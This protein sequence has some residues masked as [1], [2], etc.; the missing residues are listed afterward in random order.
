MTID[1]CTLGASHVDPRTNVIMTQTSRGPEGDEPFGELPTYS[2]LGVTSVPWD[3]DDNGAAE[4]IVVDGVGTKGA[5]IGAR[6]AR[7]AKIT[8]NAKPGDTIIHTTGPSQAAQ[9]QLKEA[10]RQSVLCTKD[11]QDKQMV[12]MLDGKNDKVAVLAFGYV[13]QIDRDTGISLSSKN[14]QHGIEITDSGVLVRGKVQL[15]GKAAPPGMCMAA[16]TPAT[17]AAIMAL[18]GPVTP[19]M[20]VSGGL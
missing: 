6:D 20:G 10:K 9:L 14:G 17:W 12:V 3:P 16:A 5:I 11:T 4:G 1:V 18:T 7:N 19:L 8:G 2:C 13:I 15:G